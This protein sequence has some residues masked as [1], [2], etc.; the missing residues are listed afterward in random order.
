MAIEERSNMALLRDALGRNKKKILIAILAVDIAVALYSF[1]MP[2]SYVSESSLMPPMDKK[3]GGGLSALV[4]GFAGGGL[5]LGGL[6]GESNQSKLFSEV[7][8]SRTIIDYIDDT[9]KLYGRG[10]YE[11]M[12]KSKFREEIADQI[13]VSLNKSGIISISVTAKTGFFSGENDKKH[14]AALARQINQNAINGLNY[15]VNTKNITNSKK[16]RIH[17]ENELTAY[18]AKSDSVARRL[19]EFQKKNKVLELDDQTKAIVE[20]AIDVGTQL[21]EVETEYNLARIEFN[22]SSPQ[23]TVKKKQAEYLKNELMRLQKGE[24]AA[25]GDFSIALNNVPTLAREYAVLYRDR[26]ILEQV[27]LYL[28]TQRHQE[29]IQEQKDMPVVDVLDSPETPEERSSPDRKM[30]IFLATFISGLLAAA[31]FIIRENIRSAVI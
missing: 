12:T 10:T 26:K 8:K 23:V 22:P 25:E 28:E 17:I 7:L 6:S 31:F 9:L 27:I 15:V 5:D 13:D 14:A 11:G 21:I 24:G 29:A 19:E 18:K 3:S 20:Q 2:Q 4:Q 30:M 16:A 1:V